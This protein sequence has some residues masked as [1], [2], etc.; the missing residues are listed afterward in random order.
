MIFGILGAG[1][2]AKYRVL[3]SMAAS[4]TA[5]VG[6]IQRRNG[7]ACEALAREF[8]VAH[9]SASVDELLAQKL[10]AVWICSPNKLHLEQ[11]LSVIATKRHVLIEKPAALTEEQ[12]VQIAAAAKKAGVFAGV[13]YCCR[14][15]PSVAAA[16]AS[17]SR[18]GEIVHVDCAL[19]VDRSV[20]KYEPWMLEPEEQGTGVLYD[21]GCHALDLLLFLGGDHW[22]VRWASKSDHTASVGGEEAAIPGS[23]NIQLSDGSGRKTASVFV[24]HQASRCS[25]V[26]II[27]TRGTMVLGFPFGKDSLQSLTFISA[28][29]VPQTRFFADSDVQLEFVEAFVTAC[30]VGDSDSFPTID[31]SVVVHRWMD[32]ARRIYNDDQC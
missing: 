10:D 17:T 12:V 4:S 26:K 11:A 5:V 15:S 24:S 13:G 31:Q 20:R 3:P 1:G 27:G 7:K 29:Q 9:R 14:Y 2:Y 16:K 25:E 18:L 21:L 8:G 19:T 22:E 30:E 6:S 28:E 32:Q 23:V